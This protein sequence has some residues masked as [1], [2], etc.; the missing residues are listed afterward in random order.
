ML[1]EVSGLVLM[2]GYNCVTPRIVSPLRGWRYHVGWPNPGL[3][4]GAI[5]CSTPSGLAV[6][7]SSRSVFDHT[8]RNA[9]PPLLKERGEGVRWIKAR[10]RIIMPPL[11]GLLFQTCNKSFSAIIISSLRDWGLSAFDHT[12]RNDS[13]ILSSP[14]IDSLQGKRNLFC[15]T[16]R[17]VTRPTPS[18]LEVSR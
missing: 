10:R 1:N 16:Y 12:E 8:E 3:T 5:N 9:L 14:A 15:G 13:V 7:I 4:P 11:R 17:R 2:G 6:Q 18:G